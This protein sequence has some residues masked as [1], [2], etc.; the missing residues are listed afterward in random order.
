MRRVL[1][2][3]DLSLRPLVARD[4]GELF[5]L[6]DTH[7]DDLRRF[8]TW[9]DRTTGEADMKYY[10]LGLDGFWKSGLTYGIL[11]RET[12]VGT[13]GFHHSDMR[14]D[15]TEIGY[16]LTPWA[17]GRGVA[18][19][20]VQMA[21]SAAFQFTEVNRIEAKIHPDNQPSVNLIEKLGFC[22][23]GLERQ[24]I[25]QG[26]RYLDSRVY[27]LLRGEFGS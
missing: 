20:S 7:R 26:T 1:E 22:Y 8:M 23:E 15:R 17:R 13:V 18:R 21:V 10:I 6:T 14:N 27:S 4:A 12:L 2:D 25:K 3:N 16:W 24:G 5:T 9:V 19:R 11:E